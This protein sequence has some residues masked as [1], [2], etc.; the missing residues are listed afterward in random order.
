MSATLGSTPILSHGWHILFARVASCSHA[1]SAKL[2]VRPSISWI[3]EMIGQGRRPS[4]S[5]SWV[6]LGSQIQLTDGRTISLADVPCERDATWA[7]KMC[8]PWDRMGVNPRM[9]E[10]DRP[11]NPFHV[12]KWIVLACCVCVCVCGKG[13]GHKRKGHYLMTMRY[14]CGGKGPNGPWVNSMEV[15]LWG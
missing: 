7:N 5:W 9:A 14:P 11:T 13:E 2:M 10:R 1:T 8:H 6:N 12:F 3:G 15:P 4:R